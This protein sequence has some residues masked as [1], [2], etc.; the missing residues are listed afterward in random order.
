MFEIDIKRLRE[1]FSQNKEK[2]DLTFEGAFRSA[3]KR[4]YERYQY[5]KKII[6][7]Y[8]S[9]GNLLSITIDSATIKKI[10]IVGKVTDLKIIEILK[11]NV[12]ADFP[13]VDYLGLDRSLQ[14]SVERT[15]GYVTLIFS[16][17]PEAFG[18]P[19]LKQLKGRKDIKEA[20]SLPDVDPAFLILADSIT[21]ENSYYEDN[22]PTRSL[23]HEKTLLNKD[24]SFFVVDYTLAV[25]SD[26]EITDTDRVQ[27]IF[28]AAINTFPPSTEC[29]LHG[30]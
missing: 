18:G 3:I 7:E 16:E 27:K 2:I 12:T 11:G 22:D 25:A 20:L 26:G 23:F 6:V 14:T 30:W 29:V 15:L 19:I 24:Q 10:Q 5:C 28:E 1:F 17:D 9:K 4:Y 13:N 21:V 8:S